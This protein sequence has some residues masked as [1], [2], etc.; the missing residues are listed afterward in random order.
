M[1]WAP[2][3]LKLDVLGLVI[4]TYSV[5]SLCPP[6]GLAVIAVLCHST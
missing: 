3:T 1:T 6:H 5:Q 2:A 4:E